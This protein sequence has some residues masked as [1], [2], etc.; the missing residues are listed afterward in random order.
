[1]YVTTTATTTIATTNTATTT[2]IHTNT[3]T[4]TATVLRSEC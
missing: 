3:A 2:I 4:T 1:M